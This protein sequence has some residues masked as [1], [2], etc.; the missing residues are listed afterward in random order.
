[1]AIY[2]GKKHAGYLYDYFMNQYIAKHLP[3]GMKMMDY[4]HYNRNRKSF[5][6]AYD[7]RFDFLG[8][9]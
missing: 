3:E 2:L 7:D 4:Y 1:M 8:T 6:P 9:K 5:S